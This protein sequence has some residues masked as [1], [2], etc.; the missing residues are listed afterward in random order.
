[1]AWRCRLGPRELVEPCMRNG[2]ARFLYELPK[3]KSKF[4]H[5]Y[6]PLGRHLPLLSPSSHLRTISTTHVFSTIRPSL[7]H[8]P[9]WLLSSTPEDQAL[10]QRGKHIRAPSTIVPVR[11]GSGSNI[12]ST[13]TISRK[14]RGSS[15]HCAKRSLEPRYYKQKWCDYASEFERKAW[16]G[17]GEA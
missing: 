8:Q 12:C 16:Q 17:Y 13:H 11:K 2:T 5:Y 6:R 15:R 1:M 7:S 3:Q 10:L 4:G 9:P 14:A